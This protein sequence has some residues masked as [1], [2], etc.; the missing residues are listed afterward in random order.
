M[1]YCEGSPEG[2]ADDPRVCA[3][4]RRKGLPGV[5]CGGHGRLVCR[6]LSLRLQELMALTLP[7]HLSYGLLYTSF[8]FA[9]SLHR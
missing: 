9:L 6:E 5:A 8:T 2:L 7:G 3:T 1:F 4:R